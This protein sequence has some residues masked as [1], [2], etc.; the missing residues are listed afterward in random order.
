MEVSIKLHPKFKDKI[1]TDQ[2]KIPIDE[3]ETVDTLLMKISRRYPRLVEIMLD[4]TTGELR[5]TQSI[6]L[7]GRR[8]RGIHTK[9]KHKDEISVLPP[10]EK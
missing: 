2:L 5:E 1:G 6:L 4:P 3:D 9:L 7:N 10:E 8:I